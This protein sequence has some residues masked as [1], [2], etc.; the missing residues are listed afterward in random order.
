[1]PVV[2][3]GAV[4]GPGGVSP[5]AGQVVRTNGVITA[6]KFNGL[7]IQ[8]EPGTEDT[9]P[10]TSEG[11]FVFTSSTPDAALQVGDHV[12]VV[13]VVLE[14]RRLEFER[15]LHLHALLQHAA[16]AV[17]VFDRDRELR[18]HDGFDVGERLLADG[19]GSISR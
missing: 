5:Y 14:E 9:D 13:E 10:A 16:D 3:I 4:Q 17:V 18:E 8:S 2:P 15:H 6:R 12:V 19:A 1:M 7:F 11:L